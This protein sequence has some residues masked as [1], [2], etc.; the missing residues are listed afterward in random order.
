MRGRA[1]VFDRNVLENPVDMPS[2]LIDHPSNQYRR[3]I[4]A[5]EPVA[6][7]SPHADQPINHVECRSG[8]KARVSASKRTALFCSSICWLVKLSQTSKA[9]G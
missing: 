3:I 4:C 5:V 7:A 2:Q 8:H 9:S 1:R 6:A